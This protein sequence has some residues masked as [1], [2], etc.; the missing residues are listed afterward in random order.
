MHFIVSFDIAM[1]VF[2]FTP[3]PAL[4]PISVSN[5]I[6]YENR[7]AVLSYSAFGSSFFYLWVIEEDTCASGGRWS[8][9]KKYKGSPYLYPCLLYPQNIWR[10]EIVF[11]KDIVMPGHMVEW[12]ETEEAGAE[13][14]EEL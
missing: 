8:W 3:M 11:C 12:D 2:T 9:T 6:I 7:L 1:E 4:D 13:N 14:D 10:N 5:S